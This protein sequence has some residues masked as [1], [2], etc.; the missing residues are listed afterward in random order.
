MPG[1][2]QVQSAAALR[3]SN[4]ECRGPTG[5]QYQVQMPHRP[6][7]TECSSMQN[8]NECSCPTGQQY[9]TTGRVQLP[10]RPAILTGCAVF[11]L[12]LLPLW[13]ETRPTNHT[14]ILS[15]THATSPTSIPSQLTQ[16]TCC[17]TM[18]HI[19]IITP[20][21]VHMYSRSTSLR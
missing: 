2:Q 5:Q 16:G 13:P 6:A 21:T 18:P 10:C 11:S 12:A 17:Q 4:T 1:D 20:N 14:S 3:A 8:S 7:I 9:T 19:H 15:P